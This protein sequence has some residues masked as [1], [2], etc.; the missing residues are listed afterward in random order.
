MAQTRVVD[1]R[2]GRR[3][4][5][6]GFGRDCD[7]LQT[8]MARD[9]FSRLARG[10]NGGVGRN[11]DHHHV[12]ESPLLVGDDPCRFGGYAG[13]VGLGDW[14]TAIRTSLWPLSG[15]ERFTNGK[16]SLA[17]VGLHGVRHHADYTTYDL[18]VLSLQE[19]G[20]RRAKFDVK[21]E[22]IQTKIS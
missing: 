5:V 18:A 21:K 15:D 7:L 10:W 14:P 1:G 4:F 13:P 16:C 2:R 3:L 20:W 9:Y 6:G 17:A 11:F 12:I 8:V 22:V 19:R